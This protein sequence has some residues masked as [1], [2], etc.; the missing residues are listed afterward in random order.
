MK[1]KSLLLLSG[2]AVSIS[3]SAQ[4]TA[5]DFT[6]TDCNSNS[7]TLFTYLD[8]EEVVVIEF[9]MGCSSCY[10]AATALMGM[11]TNYDSSQPG[12]VNFFYMDYWTG[13]TCASDVAPMMSANNFDAGFDNAGAQKSYY[14][15][16]SPMPGIVIVAGSNHSV[17]YEK[18]SF[19]S[20]DV[21]TMTAAIDNFFA[22]IGIEENKLTEENF[23]LYPNPAENNV[24]LTTTLE[25]SVTGVSIEVTDITG[26]VVAVLS[27]LT[28]SE[29]TNSINIPLNDLESG[30]YIV[31][32]ITSETV[33]TKNI[34]KI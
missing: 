13:N 31:R 24:T 11:Q 8:A 21:A 19:A 14:M 7:H 18:N 29:G 2:I 9:G 16:G 5:Q 28:L 20:G 26:K 30:Q 3:A 4:T 32:I 1:I 33:I 23:T 6:L 17:I 10:T 34:Q 12:K 27:D 22:T 15:T 25:N